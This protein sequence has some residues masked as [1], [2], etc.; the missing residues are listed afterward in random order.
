MTPTSVHG[1][2]PSSWRPRT[3]AWC[4]EVPLYTP[5][6]SEPYG[7]EFVYQEALKYDPPFARDES[8]GGLRSVSALFYASAQ[9]AADAAPGRRRS[10]RSPARGRRWQKMN[11]GWF[12]MR[13]AWRSRRMVG[14]FEALIQ[15]C[16]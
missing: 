13:A 3:R 15:P 8:V 12:T 2:A 11:N 5:A 14:G 10:C 7:P 16:R 1:S 6:G 4:D 9:A